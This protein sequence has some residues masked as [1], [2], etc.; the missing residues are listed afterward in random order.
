[1]NSC[2]VAA[3]TTSRALVPDPAEIEYL[4]SIV[5]NGEYG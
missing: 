1:M 2:I 5:Q 3:P 4:G